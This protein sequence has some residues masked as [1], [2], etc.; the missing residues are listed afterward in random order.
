MSTARTRLFEMIDDMETAMFTT[1]RADG[2]LVSRP[3]ANQARSDGADLWF[4]T[5]KG[6]GKLKEI[7][8]DPQVSLTY[9]KDRTREWVSI[10]G[11]AKISRDRA[12]IKEL[13][14][15]DWRAWF[16]DDG[17]PK[18]GTPDDPRIILIGVTIRSVMFMEVNKPA[19]VAVFELIKGIL[20]HKPPNLGKMHT[21]KGRPRKSAKKR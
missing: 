11:R 12:K 19:P 18:A 15:P 7:E 14:R 21:L 8:R 2:R 4:V 10:S 20:T 13:F 3:M 9:Y 5:Y 6:S 1:R 16:A 17:G